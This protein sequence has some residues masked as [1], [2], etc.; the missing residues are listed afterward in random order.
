METAK[1][2]L[3]NPA[4]TV[5]RGP[6]PKTWTA[7]GLV[8]CSVRGSKPASPPSSTTVKRKTY[9]YEKLRCP[10]HA[11]DR[12]DGVTHPSIRTEKAEHELAELVFMKLEA[13][14][15]SPEQS[16]SADLTALRV[17]H[18]E[19][20]RKRQVQ[21]EIAE[22]PGADVSAARKRIAELGLK[23]ADADTAITAAVASDTRA[24]LHAREASTDYGDWA[25]AEAT[26][27]FPRW[28]ERWAAFPVR[29]VRISCGHC[30][31]QSPSCG[32]RKPPTTHKPRE[33]GRA[34]GR[35]GVLVSAVVIYLPNFH[36]LYAQHL[37]AA[38]LRFVEKLLQ[39]LSRALFSL[40]IRGA[41]FGDV[42]VVARHV[43]ALAIER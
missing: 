38:V 35:Q 18:A 15:H 8:Q 10:K 41:L 28:E 30:S 22:A 6:K 2:I 26:K 31:S 5:A 29:S 36:M 14:A 33:R 13:L 7:V 40:Q 12:N 20:A 43:G 24:S 27:V 42:L 37:R 9:R 25:T 23:L 1:A 17:K 21:Q 11:G 4:R 34:N 16:E 19:L 32:G 3:E 39:K